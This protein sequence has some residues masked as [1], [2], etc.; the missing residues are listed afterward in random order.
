MQLQ[1]DANEQKWTRVLPV[2]LAALPNCCFLLCHM[3]TE[4]GEVKCLQQKRSQNRKKN[5][6]RELSTKCMSILRPGSQ[7]G[8]LVRDTSGPLPERPAGKRHLSGASCCSYTGHKALLPCAQ[9]SFLQRGRHRH[10]AVP[11]PDCPSLHPAVS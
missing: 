8:L 1:R 10:E 3:M 7:R 9:I 5:R 6:E 2:C 4:S 11:C